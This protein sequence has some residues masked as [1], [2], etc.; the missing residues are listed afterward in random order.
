MRKQSAI[1]QELQGLRSL[2]MDSQH[3]PSGIS[4]TMPPHKVDTAHI[5]ETAKR[6]AAPPSATA[7][8]YINRASRQFAMA[9]P[10]AKGETG[11]A[12]PGGNPSFHSTTTTSSS[13]GRGGAMPA[14]GYSTFPPAGTMNPALTAKWQQNAY[15]QAS[16]VKAFQEQARRVAFMRTQQQQTQGRGAPSPLVASSSQAEGATGSPAPPGLL[17]GGTQ[18]TQIQAHVRAVMQQQA[19]IMQQQQLQAQALHQ[20]Q[21][22]LAAAAQH[23]GETQ[24][25]HAATSSQALTVAIS[26]AP[27]QPGASHPSSNIGAGAMLPAIAG[28]TPLQQEEG[29]TA[30]GLGTT[31]PFPDGPDTITIT[32]RAPNEVTNN[33]QGTNSGPSA[34]LVPSQGDI[35]PDNEDGGGIFDDAEE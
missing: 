6:L 13:Q 28:S 11:T 3:L 17:M 8:G 29:A 21:A 14:P 26:P 31:M 4:V 1:Q 7:A 10:F 27:A 32:V 16:R 12:A 2:Q 33:H 5:V 22:Q 25:L 30:A 24:G 20:Q 34:P 23:I 35:A 9:P 15:A 18:D 19:V